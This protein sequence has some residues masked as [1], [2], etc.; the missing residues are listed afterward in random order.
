MPLV[1]VGDSSRYHALEV[2]GMEWKTAFLQFVGAYS[3]PDE[4]QFTRRDI[5]DM[6]LSGKGYR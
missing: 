2:V 3:I 5:L 6:A 1:S 4:R